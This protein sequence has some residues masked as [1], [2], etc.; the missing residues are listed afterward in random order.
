MDAEFEKEKANLEQEI[1]RVD[2]YFANGWVGD[3]EEAASMRS[4]RATCVD[5][6]VLQRA[7]RDLGIRMFRESQGV[8]GDG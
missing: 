7:A 3:E 8:W 5:D 6:I 4:Y 1:A 2:D